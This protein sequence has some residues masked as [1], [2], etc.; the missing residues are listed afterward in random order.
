VELTYAVANPS[1]VY[2]SVQT[3]GGEIWRSTNGGRSFEKREG[4]NEDG[5][6]A[7]YL[8]DQGWYDNVIWA[9]DPTNAD[10]VL[11]GGIDLWK[12]T[13]GGQTLTDISTWWSPQSVHADQ[14]CIVAHPQFDGVSNKTVFFG[15]DGGVFK[16]D[17]IHTAG[18]DQIPPRI[19]G[20]HELDNTY[21]VTQFYGAAGHAG[22]GV[23][24]GGAQDNGT[25][26][27]TPDQGTE[28]WS[29]MF[30]GDGG[31]CASDPN[32]PQCFYGEYVF[33]NIHRS[34]DG[35]K[36]ADFISGQAWNGHDW[37]WKPV[38]FRIPDAKSQDA[39]FIAP[40]ILDPNDSNRLLAGGLSLWRT[41]NAKAPN[42]LTAGPLWASIKNPV[43]SHIS[44]IA[45][46]SGDQ[47]LAWVGHEDGQICKTGNASARVPVWQRVDG[48]GPSGLIAKRMCTRVVI[49]PSNHAR[50]YVTFGG[51]QRGNV[52]KTEDGG[53]TWHDIGAGLPEVPVRSLAIHPRRSDFLFIGTEVG[54]FASDD[55]GASWSAANEGPTSCSVDDLFWMN[56]TLVCATHGRGMFQINLNL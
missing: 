43:G 28:Q 53:A 54:A 1:I 52:W 36:T 12:S 37:I 14:H 45:V 48:T 24:I 19:H 56:E 13:D 23:I 39:L 38:P 35:G 25:L 49:D 32:D 6:P 30:G 31:W 50:V 22:S 40:F 46:A 17:D 9:S 11:V 51:Y 33:L 5:H 18:N 27:F 16:T 15:N 8:G 7:G 29:S 2:A 20:W 3:E 4:L 41:N 55:A 42:T 44:A 26:R 47:D 21:G 10:F 34:T